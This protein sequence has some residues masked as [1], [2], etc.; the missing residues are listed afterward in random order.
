MSCDWGTSSFRLRLVETDGLRIIAEVAHQNGIAA[1]FASW[2]KAGGK[3]E[4]RLSFYLDMIRGAA[5]EIEQK[6]GNSPVGAPLIISGMASSSLGMVDLLYKKLPFRLD[7]SDLVISRLNTASDLPDPIWVVSGARTPDDVM[8]GEETLL[9]GATSQVP[10][11]GEGIFVFPGTH[12]KHIRIGNG[13]AT[14]FATYMTGEFFNLLSQKSVLAETLEK[15]EG[16]TD[17]ENLAYFKKGIKKSLEGNLLHDCFRVR[18]DYLSG[19]AGKSHNYHYLSGLLIGTE[20]K[21]LALEQNLILTLISSGAL[22]NSYEIAFRYLGISD[23]LTV[24]SAEDSIVNGHAK[25][26][27]WII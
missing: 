27:S 2:Q 26:L 7:G 21:G 15:G 23:R 8:R 19:R 13:F 14:D 10:L 6:T 22:R 9:V 25:I 4:E 17:P 16:L 11:V 24:L 12:S 18:P 5:V 20:I 3:P 1:T